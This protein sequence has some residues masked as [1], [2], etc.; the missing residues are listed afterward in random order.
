MALQLG[1]DEP[2]VT[3]P[4]ELGVVGERIDARRSE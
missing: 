4:S 1:Y 3:D 2:N